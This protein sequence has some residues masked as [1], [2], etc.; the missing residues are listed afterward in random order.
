MLGKVGRRPDI[1]TPRVYLL[2]VLS[3][4]H[5]FQDGVVR[6]HWFKGDTATSVNHEAVPGP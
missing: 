6:W 4:S 3:K 1:Q 5:D 2:L